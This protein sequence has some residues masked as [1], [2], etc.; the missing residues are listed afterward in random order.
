MLH[1]YIIAFGVAFFW[2]SARMYGELGGLLDVSAPSSLTD[3]PVGY[4]FPEPLSIQRMHAGFRCGPFRALFLTRTLLFLSR[5]NN[6]YPPYKIR[7]LLDLVT[8]GI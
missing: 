7:N 1:F 5:P 3:P 2:H 8:F 4:K 6:G